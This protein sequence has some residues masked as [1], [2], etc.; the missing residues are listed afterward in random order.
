MA[1]MARLQFGRLSE[2]WSGEASDFTPL[3]SE[4]LDA[5]GAEINVD[6]ASVGES[7]VAT[8]GERRI[9]IVAQGEDGSEFVIENQYGRGDHDHLTRGLA[10]AVARRARGLVVVAEAHRDEF[11]AVA[12]YLNELAEHDPDRGIAVWLVEA[13]AVRI[14]DSAWAPLFSTVVEPNAFTATVEQT[15][16]AQT[17]LGSLEEFWNQFESEATLRAVQDVVSHWIDSGH[18][19]RLGPNHVVL[20]ARGPATSGIRTVVALYS[21]GR[22]MIP[23]SAYAGTNSGIPIEDLTS[24]E[25]RQYADALFGLDGSERQART[26]ESWLTA[27][28]AG[29]LTEFCDRVAH[30]YAQ[31]IPNNSASQ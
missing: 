4:Q 18:R 8:T 10:Y 12:Q 21:D 28:S 25:F 30:A 22:V 31:A 11:R 17:N 5:L 6:L 3:L 13:K 14:G 9:D 29:V 26:R 1:T 2:A 24:N 19:T 20:A 23:F 15:R 16:R 7:E 27:D